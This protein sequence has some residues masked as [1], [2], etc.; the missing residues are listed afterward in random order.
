V[1]HQVNGIARCD[2]VKQVDEAERVRS[3][4]RLTCRAIFGP[5]ET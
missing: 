3:V 5:V 2:I 1:K 4:D